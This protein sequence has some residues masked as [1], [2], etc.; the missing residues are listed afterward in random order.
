MP[1]SRLWVKFHSWNCQTI[2]E[3]RERKNRKNSI[4]IFDIY[5]SFFN[6][7]VSII[8]LLWRYRK[9]RTYFK[10]LVLKRA[11]TLQLKKS[12]GNDTLLWTTIPSSYMKQK[13]IHRS[14]MYQK[15]RYRR[16]SFLQLLH[17]KVYKSP[18]FMQS[19]NVCQIL[20]SAIFFFAL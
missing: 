20:W 19:K 6:S 8:L 17:L 7:G 13:S 2:K 11:I 10:T 3:S 14:K 5:N 16:K 15:C 9:I 18:L 4:G 1:P 12:Q